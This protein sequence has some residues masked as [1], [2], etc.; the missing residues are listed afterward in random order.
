MGMSRLFPFALAQVPE[1]ITWLKIIPQIGTILEPSSSPR[2]IYSE[3]QTNQ[4]EESSDNSPFI[5]VDRGRC[6]AG[7]GMQRCQR[8]DF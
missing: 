1:V 7:D 3:R 8:D 2:C 4:R 5:F 6:F